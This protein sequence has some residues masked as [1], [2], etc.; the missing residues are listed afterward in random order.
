MQKTAVTLSVFQIALVETSPFSGAFNFVEPSSSFKLRPLATLRTCGN[1]TIR[2]QISP[3]RDMRSQ[4]RQCNRPWYCRIIQAVHF[5]DVPGHRIAHPNL[6]CRNSVLTTHI[7]LLGMSWKTD[8]SSLKKTK[9]PESGEHLMCNLV[10]VQLLDESVSEEFQSDG[11][12]PSVS[13]S[14][15]LLEVASAERV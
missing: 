6:T 14:A 15:V 11:T 13:F 8:T 1:E 9:F 4:K 7:R 2:S 10:C 12:H 3:D 5:G